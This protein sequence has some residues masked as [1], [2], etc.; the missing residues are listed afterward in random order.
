MLRRTFSYRIS[1]FG[2]VEVALFWLGKKTR[3]K[4]IIN[5]CYFFP[6]QFNYQIDDVTAIDWTERLNEK[7]TKFSHRIGRSR[8]SKAAKIFRSNF[9]IGISF[10]FRK[11]WVKYMR[12]HSLIVESHHCCFW[13]LYFFA[14]I[15]F[16]YHRYV[17]GQRW[18]CRLFFCPPFAHSYSCL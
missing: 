14:L 4:W 15:A 2:F 17:N 10:E 3:H 12:A 8:V 11:K 1:Y 9:I 6:Y 5:V 7:Y 16:A 18:I 13:Y